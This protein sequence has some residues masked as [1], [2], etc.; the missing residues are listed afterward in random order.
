MYY[1]F[2]TKKYEFIITGY[3]LPLMRCAFSL[4]SK[5]YSPL[6]GKIYGSGLHPVFKDN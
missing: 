1:I 4:P 2:I 3:I 5:R 6:I